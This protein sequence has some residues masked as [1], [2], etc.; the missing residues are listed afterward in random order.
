MPPIRPTPEPAPVPCGTA[1]AVPTVPAVATLRASAATIAVF[2]PLQ[3]GGRIAGE[4]VTATWGSAPV[5][6]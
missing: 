4:V 1:A 2:L 6:T 3:R 5:G